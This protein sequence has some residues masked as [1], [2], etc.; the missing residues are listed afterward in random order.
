MPLDNL[1]KSGRARGRGKGRGRGRGGAQ[2]S[3]TN[4]S[5]RGRGVGRGVNR[6]ARGGGRGNVMSRLGYAKKQ[7]QA[8]NGTGASEQQKGV[9]DL[10]DVLATKNK[11]LVV[12][13][14]AKISPKVSPMKPSKKGSRGREHPANT[15]SRSPL[16]ISADVFHSPKFKSPGGGSSRSKDA[17]FNKGYREMERSSSRRL[18]TTAEAKKITVT[19]QGLS[20]TTSEVRRR[21]KDESATDLSLSARVSIMVLQDS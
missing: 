3:G 17:I 8:Q 13:L 19:V 18:P 20:K 14:R 5:Q 15:R 1:V 21:K 10:R 11:T 4:F 12:D 6:G 16:T 7:T 2:N 9:S